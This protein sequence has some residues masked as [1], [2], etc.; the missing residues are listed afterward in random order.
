MEIFSFSSFV[1]LACPP[2]KSSKY[3]YRLCSLKTKKDRSQR[4]PKS[5][6][7]IEPRPFNSHV[8]VLD[9]MKRPSNGLLT[10]NLMVIKILTVKLFG[11][12]LLCM[13]NIKQPEEID[14]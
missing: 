4:C 12:K 9:T 14:R 3:A 6:L 5:R 13:I 7:P 1:A 11:L 10:C 8:Q 2:I